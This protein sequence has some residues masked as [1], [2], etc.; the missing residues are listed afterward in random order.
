ML[1]LCQKLQFCTYDRQN[2]SGDRLSFGQPWSPLPLKVEVLDC[3]WLAL[4]PDIHGQTWIA[5]MTTDASWMPKIIIRTHLSHKML[6]NF[7]PRCHVSSRKINWAI[8]E[9]RLRSRAAPGGLLWVYAI[10]TSPCVV[11]MWKHELST[12]PEV[13]KTLRCC[14]RI[15]PQQ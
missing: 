9:V 11:I 15:K 8:V 13:R 7:K 5:N 4:R 1:V 6:Q 10:F 14:H 3:P 12:K 2:F